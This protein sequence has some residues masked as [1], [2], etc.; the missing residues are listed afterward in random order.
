MIGTNS[1]TIADIS[2]ILKPRRMSPSHRN[3]TI[4]V[5]DD[6]AIDCVTHSATVPDS[7]EWKLNGNTLELSADRERDASHG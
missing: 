2:M 3:L 6:I 4:N 5:G 7:V 1:V